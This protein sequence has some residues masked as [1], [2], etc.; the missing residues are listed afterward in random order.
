MGIQLGEMF[1]LSW[2]IGLVKHV[3]WAQWLHNFLIHLNS[4]RTSIQFTM[5][6]ELERAIPFL[7]FLAIR[8]QMTLAT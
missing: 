1:K 2:L 3:T 8:K 7:D 4:L 5:E 6:I